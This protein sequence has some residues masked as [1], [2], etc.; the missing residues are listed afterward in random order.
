MSYV[1]SKLTLT[2]VNKE[3]G[4]TLYGMGIKLLKIVIR[5]IDNKQTW[6]SHT[7]DTS[8]LFNNIFRNYSKHE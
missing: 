1:C 7:S 2:R 8:S 5:T 4:Y 3:L 6:F